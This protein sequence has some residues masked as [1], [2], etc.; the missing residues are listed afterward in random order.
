MNTKVQEF[1]QLNKFKEERFLPV[2]GFEERFFISD[3]GRIISHN[4]RNN[5]IY[6]LNPHLDSLGYYSTQLRNKPISRKCRIHQLVG[7]HFCEMNNKFVRMCWNHIDGNKKNNHY[8]NLE[9]ITAKEN[10]A[11]AVIKGLHNLKGENHFNSKVSSEDVVKMR[12]LRKLGYTHKSIA[13]QFNISRKQA[14]DI[15]NGV[16]WGWLSSI[17]DKED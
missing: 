2:K 6:F 9:Y 11:H 12:H 13:I 1:I 4:L 10:C 16:N 7:E 14:G 15:C 3:H 8:K 5:K 17:P